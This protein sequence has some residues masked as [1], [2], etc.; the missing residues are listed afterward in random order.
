MQCRWDLNFPSPRVRELDTGTPAGTGDG[1]LQTGKAPKEVAKLP[2]F[3][4]KNP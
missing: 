2:L 4:K 1:S 3:L